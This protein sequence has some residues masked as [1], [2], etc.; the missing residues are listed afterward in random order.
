VNF[1]ALAVPFFVAFMG[2]EWWLARRRRLAL[3]RLNDAVVDLSSGI[4]QQVGLIFMKGALFVLYLWVYEHGRMFELSERSV[5]TWILAIVLVDAS[6]YAW[7]RLSHEVNWMWAAH[8]VHHSS[9]DYNLAVALRQSLLTPWTLAPFHLPLAVLGVPP[10]VMFTADAFNTLYQFWIHTQ[11]VG[12]LG[13]LERWLNTPSLHRVHHGINPRYLDKNYAGIFVV[14]DRMFGTYEVESEPV[15]YGLVKPLH[16]F[17]PYTAQFHYGVELWRRARGAPRLADKLA[18]LLKGPRYTRAGAEPEPAP[19][20]VRPETFRKHDPP[21]TPQLA[22]YICV[23]LALVVV[24]ATGL[25]FFETVWP[26][27]QLALGAALVF[28]AI[29]GWGGLLERRR[30][31]PPAQWV[32]LAATAAAAAA[33]GGLGVLGPAAAVASLAG[34]AGLGLWFHRLAPSGTAHASGA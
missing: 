28:L 29:L 5:W 34:A 17:N 33:L 22:R 21:L 26:T 3:Y 2:L 1:I 6:Y 12:R 8:V 27:W 18:L 19:P 7:H 9:E 32:L 16:S 23:Q 10:L 24:G 15:V 31:A 13:V 4:V 25:M 20:E 30:W 14:W 11:L